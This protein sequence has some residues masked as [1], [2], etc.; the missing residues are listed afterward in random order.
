MLERISTRFEELYGHQN[1]FVDFDFGE[2][3]QVPSTQYGV[4][5]CFA[6]KIKPHAVHYLTNCWVKKTTPPPTTTTTTPKMA[7]KINT[8]TILAQTKPPPPP[9][10]KKQFCQK[11][12]PLPTYPLCHICT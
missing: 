1:V 5:N 6:V 3:Q 10:G 11:I 8:P 4:H 9:S 2:V 12:T 7:K